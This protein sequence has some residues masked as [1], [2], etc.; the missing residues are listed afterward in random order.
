MN[1]DKIKNLGLFFY[2]TAVSAGAAAV[3]PLDCTAQAALD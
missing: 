1:G 3:S 2:E